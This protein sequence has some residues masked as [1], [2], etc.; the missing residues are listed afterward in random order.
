MKLYT[1]DYKVNQYVMEYF[2]KIQ[3]KI[4]MKYFLKIKFMNPK[5]RIPVFLIEMS[6]GMVT[7]NQQLCIIKVSWRE[8]NLLICDNMDF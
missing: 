4:V 6:S 3:F 1:E 5:I 8:E 7:E 2:F